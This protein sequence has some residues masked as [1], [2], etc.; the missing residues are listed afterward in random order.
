MKTYG[1]RRYS[2]TILDLG[3]RRMWVDPLVDVMG[4]RK[5]CPCRESNSDRPARSYTD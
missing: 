5:I 4:K 1:K 2:A 3:T